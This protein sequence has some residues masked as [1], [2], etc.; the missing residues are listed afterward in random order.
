ML[1]G[2]SWQS[3]CICV[4]SVLLVL[5]DWQ[6]KGPKRL[7]WPQIRPAPRA[8]C[9]CR[10]ASGCPSNWQGQQRQARDG[11]DAACAFWAS[12]PRC[13]IL[14]KMQA[15]MKRCFCSES[16]LSPPFLSSNRKTEVGSN[17][18]KSHPDGG[19]RKS[20]GTAGKGVPA[21]HLCLCPAPLSCPRALCKLR[22]ISR[23]LGKGYLTAARRC[24]SAMLRPSG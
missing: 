19:V 14:V 17:S 16:L 13:E 6:K 15:V 23:T 21:G 18:W 5:L 12:P 10:R 20:S 3:G 1:P 11:S 2:R 9:E 8:L 4:Q 22:W 24:P 7:S